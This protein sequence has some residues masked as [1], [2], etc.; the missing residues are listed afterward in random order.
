MTRLDRLGL[1]LLAGGL[2]LAVVNL[3]M[4]WVGRSVSVWQAPLSG[5]LMAG[6]LVLLAVNVMKGIREDAEE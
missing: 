5:V 3:L 1:A 4:W 2:G 6:G